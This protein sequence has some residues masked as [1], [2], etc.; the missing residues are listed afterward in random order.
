MTNQ[1]SDILD[2]HPVTPVTPREIRQTTVLL[3][4]DYSRIALKAEH[5]PGH[6][7]Q[8]YPPSLAAGAE[9]LPGPRLKCQE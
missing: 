4:W 9:T 2:P 5:T 1:L 3:L 6:T 8:T 7:T